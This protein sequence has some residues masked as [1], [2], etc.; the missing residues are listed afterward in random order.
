MGEEKAKFYQDLEYL[1]VFKPFLD[2]K[3]YNHVV[4]QRLRE[5]L[6]N[7]FFQDRKIRVLDC[8]TG[9]GR[10]LIRLIKDGFLRNAFI[11]AFDVNRDLL[12]DMP[13]LFE[14][15]ANLNGWSY[16]PLDRKDQANFQFSITCEK[17]GIDIVV[18]GFVC[19][20]YDVGEMYLEQVDLVTGQA[21]IEHV[22]SQL[23]YG[24]LLG[25]LRSSSLVYFSMNCDGWFC[26]T[27]CARGAEDRDTKIMN[28]FNDLAM[29]DQNFG[30]E[31]GAIHGGRA[32][33]GRNLP[34]DF[35]RRNLVTL[36]YGSSDWVVTP[37]DQ[38][39]EELG[40]LRH[41]LLEIKDI[42]IA[43]KAS[44]MR[45]KWNVSVSEISEWH[46]EKFVAIADKSIGFT[47]VQKDILGRKI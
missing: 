43:E 45:S 12:M 10:G 18:H 25:L 23:A 20:V 29:N 44:E 16:R 36:V 13:R 2:K 14:E 39:R 5:M 11:E 34:Y 22:N 27:P 7:P 35:Q 32:F 41:T 28:L 31:S 38:S 15:H 24:R 47:C 33:C 30:N 6:A 19:S 9:T 46:L 8:G 21:F 4:S 42:C 1:N 37:Y 40:F 3:A 17:E 26:Y